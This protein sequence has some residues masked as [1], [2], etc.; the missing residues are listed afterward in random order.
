MPSFKHR[1]KVSL[2]RIEGRDVFYM[3]YRH[4]ETGRKVKRSTGKTIRGDAE[5]EAAKWEELLRSGRDNNLELSHDVRTERR[6]KTMI[7]FVEA[8]GTNRVKIGLSINIESRIATLQTG[9][10]VKL[11][12]LHAECGGKQRENQLHHQFAADWCHGEW[13]VFSDAIRE[14]VSVTSGG[15]I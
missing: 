3:Q 8:I 7:Y 9:C 1:C 14:Y 2:L 11:A 4:P 15:P 12:I 5:R 6:A 10:P 13:F